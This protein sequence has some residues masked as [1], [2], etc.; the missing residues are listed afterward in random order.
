METTN[1][2][3]VRP[4]S[5]SLWSGIFA[6]PFAWALVFQV[7]YALVDYICRNRAFWIPWAMLVVGLLICA[8]GAFEAR[9]GGQASVPVPQRARFMSIAGMALSISFAVFLIAMAIPHLFLGECD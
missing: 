9:R 2:I 8:F 6:G 1:D 4:S 3:E 5:V 7:K